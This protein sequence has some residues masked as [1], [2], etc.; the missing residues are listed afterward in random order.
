MTL[1]VEHDIK[2]Q[3]KVKLITLLFLLHAVAQ[4]DKCLVRHTRYIQ[5]Y[6]LVHLH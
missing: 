6:K 5:M 4:Y 3:I 2:Q 1:A